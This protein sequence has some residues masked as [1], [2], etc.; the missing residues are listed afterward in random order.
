MYKVMIVDDEPPIIRNVKRLLEKCSNNFV[1]AADA[2]NGCEALEKIETVKPDIVFSDIKMPVMDGLTL[3]EKLNE[4]HPE[5]LPVIISGYEDF[6]FAK[7]A[8]K[9]GVVDY[10]LK[11]IEPELMSEL[12]EHLSVRLDKIYDTK[13]IEFFQRVIQFNTIDCAFSSE[14]LNYNYFYSLVLRNGSLPS[15]HSKNFFIENCSFI[16]PSDL[17]V[18]RYYKDINKFWVLNGDDENEAIILFASLQTLQI[19]DIANTLFLEL[20]Q[21]GN[22]ITA[23][24]NPVPIKLNKLSSNIQQSFKVLHQCL[25]I[26]KHQLIVGCLPPSL[27][28]RHSVALGSN[29]EN[30][31]TVII[32]SNSFELLKDELSKLFSYWEQESFPQMYVEKM[33]IQIVRIIEKSSPLIIHSNMSIS[34]EQQLEEVLTFSTDFGSLLRGVW[35]IFEE[36]LNIS[37]AANENRNISKEFFQEVETYV[38]TNMAEPLTLLGMCHLFGISQPYLSRLFRK[39]TNLSFNEYVTNLRI[40]EAK[41]LMR[42]QPGMLLKDIAEIVGYPD[43]RYFSRIFK[44][45]TGITPSE[46]NN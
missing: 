23:V 29:L 17:E 24:L 1:V 26:G 19:Q 11:P 38:S 3:A 45:I 7:Q 28:E 43:Q 13:I 32:Q 4:L 10:L 31:L 8:L 46:F 25:V 6:S 27:C 9:A 36:V 44:S 34:V 5:I 2:F 18:L 22:C 14:H 12:L 15:R 21:A 39:Y 35:D 41:R 16:K 30:K 20:V 33:L 42:E 37:K 40:N